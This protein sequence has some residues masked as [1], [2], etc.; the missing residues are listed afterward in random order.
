MNRLAPQSMAGFLSRLNTVLC[1]VVNVTSFLEVDR[2]TSSTS[3]R[4]DLDLE[5][6][7][8]TTYDRARS[9]TSSRQLS[10]CA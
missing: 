5:R 3:N 6:D 7:S 1:R 4:R 10:K 9:V 2:T 8:R